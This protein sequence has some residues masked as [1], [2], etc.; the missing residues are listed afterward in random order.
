M[1][2]LLKIDAGAK[3]IVSSG[4]SDD[5]IMSNYEEFGFRGAITKPYQMEDLSEILHAVI[6]GVV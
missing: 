4:Y 6:N 5:T 3:A 1:M 2:K